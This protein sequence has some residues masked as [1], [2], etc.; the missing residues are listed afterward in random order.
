MDSAANSMLVPVGSGGTPLL[1]ASTT[2]FVRRNKN[3]SA[4]I[5][6]DV[7]HIQLLTI[8]ICDLPPSIFRHA[9]GMAL[10]MAL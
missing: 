9:R 5:I 2:S 1:R 6:F 8:T 4:R 7:S 3:S 10:G